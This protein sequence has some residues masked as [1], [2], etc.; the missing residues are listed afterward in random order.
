V[1]H[2]VPGRC[3]VTGL[4]AGTAVTH[5]PRPGLGVLADAGG[6]A[7][8]LAVPPPFEGGT[9][10]IGRHAHLLEYPGGPSGADVP[11]AQ[12]R[13]DL[14]VADPCRRPRAGTAR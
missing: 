3:A 2:P 12:C 1:V 13:E 7:V 4:G 9:A 10:V 6:G 5:G 14:G 11:G 8:G